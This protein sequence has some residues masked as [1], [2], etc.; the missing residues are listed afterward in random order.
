MELN[1]PEGINYECTGCG[2]CCSGW[3]VPLTQTDYE[4]IAS[5][6][7]ISLDPN[8]KAE[9]LF[10]ALKENEKVNTPYSHA[11]KPEAGGQCPFLKN[12]L[13]FIHSQFGATAKPAICQLFPYSFNETPDGVFATVSF[14]SRGAILN[15]GRSLLEQKEYLKTKYIEFQR[16][17]PNHHP[18]WSKLKLSSN[19]PLTWA[20][21]SEIENPLLAL[22]KKSDISIEER[23]LEGASYLD[24]VLV[25]R[26]GERAKPESRKNSQD[27]D[28]DG[29]ASITINR[30]DKI[31]FITLYKR[32]FP[33]DQTRA[34]G[35]GQLSLD[36][37]SFINGS[38]NISEY[39]KLMLETP[40]VS[41]MDVDDQVQDLI[42][43]FFYS[44]FFA[45]LYFGAGFGQLSLI[46]GFNHLAL[47]VALLKFKVR[48][49]ASGH[50]RSKINMEDAVFA[51]VQLE[52][53]LGELK[54]SPYGAA[55]L[56]L[57]LSSQQRMRRIISI[58]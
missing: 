34:K 43:R 53:S 26:L 1:I 48:Q 38:F 41:W 58:S 23:F 50:S 20:E 51:V 7:W 28:K 30:W 32:Y 19:V 15:A 2:K 21:Y 36:L 12:N 39:D 5:I 6:D 56:E 29:Q 49:I 54:I 10:R 52:K 35:Y 40:E 8:L 14:I 42:N 46:T 44:R 24:S 17:F 18:N 55:V 27:M 33:N 47:T 31:L 13:C 57:L 16:L 4:R 22:M 9:K 25:D 37:G 11:I 3:S 45:K